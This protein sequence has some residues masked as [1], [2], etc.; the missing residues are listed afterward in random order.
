MAFLLTDVSVGQA[1]L[2]V[3]ALGTASFGLVD[4]SKSAFGGLSNF[5]FGFVKELIEDILEPKSALAT[6]ILSS[7]KGNWINGS[8]LA[9]QEIKAKSLILLGLTPS[10]AFA[11]AKSVNLEGADGIQALLTKMQKSEPMD[12]AGRDL[13]GRFDLLL[14]SRLDETYQ[15]AD[16]RYRNVCKA[17]AMLIA[18]GLACAGF[19]FAFP[20]DWATD[21]WKTFFKSAMAGALAGPLAPVAKDIASALS[22]GTKAAQALGK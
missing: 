18:I 16:Q 4:G 5:G 10:Q 22:A 11:F 20:D 14:T 8:P 13:W 3:G 21:P 2:A 15:R 9:D 19:Y 17:V 12:A 1:L 7:L 6:S